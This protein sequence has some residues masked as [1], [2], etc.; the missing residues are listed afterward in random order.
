MPRLRTVIRNSFFVF[1]GQAFGALTALIY[2][3]FLA[4][5]L[6]EAGYGQYAYVYAFVGLFQAFSTLGLN[7]ILLRESARQRDNAGSYLGHT[8]RLKLVLSLSTFLLIILLNQVVNERDIHAFVLICA[9]ET[10]IRVYFNANVAIGRAFE[11][12]EYEMLIVIIDRGVSLLGV[13]VVVTADLGFTAIFLA[14]LGGS[15]AQALVGTLVIWRRLAKPR[16]LPVAGLNKRLLKEAWP[17]GLGLEAQ[18]AYQRQGIVLLRQWHTARVVGLYSAAYRM[19]QFTQIIAD[20]VASASSPVFSRLAKAS[21]LELT[22]AFN[23]IVRYLLLCGLLLSI[24]IWAFAPTIVAVLL[25][26]EFQ[27]S[28]TIL[29]WLAPVVILAF[30]SVLFSRFLQATDKQKVDALITGTAVIFNL[31]LNLILIPLYGYMGLVWALLASETVACTV[32]GFFALRQ[33]GAF[34]WRQ[35]ILAPLGGGLVATA[36]LFLLRDRPPYVSALAAGS[37]LI[38]VFVILAAFP[39]LGIQ[40]IREELL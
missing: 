17:I 26:P 32:G 19:F 16:F 14:F 8:L 29:R 7:Q 36:I 12:M 6:G 18:F 39:T 21:K 13:L 38:A 30:M 3:P 9:L 5:Y 22:S 37:V 40:K 25:G 4:R 31:A 28:E 15:L 33:V 11:R 27:E 23:R 34:A 35:S 1:G 24:A 2:T 10:L 20:S